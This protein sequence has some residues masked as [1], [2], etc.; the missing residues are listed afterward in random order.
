ME[1]CFYHQKHRWNSSWFMPVAVFFLEI[2]RLPFF[3]STPPS[4]PR[5]PFER[6]QVN[7]CCACV[8]GLDDDLLCTNLHD[9]GH[10]TFHSAY[11]VSKQRKSAIA[12]PVVGACLW[13]Y[14]LQCAIKPIIYVARSKRWINRLCRCLP[15]MSNENMPSCFS[16]RNRYSTV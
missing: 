15:E 5:T 12:Q 9:T 16:S 7:T 1:H 3:F 14:W 13:L 4:K 10:A 2:F 11:I 8:F 6:G